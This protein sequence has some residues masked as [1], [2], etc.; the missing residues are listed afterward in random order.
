MQKKEDNI[1]ALNSI[2]KS[3]DN[4]TL[5]VTLDGK[6]IDQTTSN[7]LITDITNQLSAEQ[8][9][10]IIN[11][12]QVEYIN[13]NGL[14]SLISILTKTRTRGGE[15]ILCNINEKIEK[16]LLIT[17]LNSVFNTADSI[18][19]AIQKMNLFNQN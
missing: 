5:L 1:Q 15:V 10:V 4:R 11:L 13:S 18:E 12:E 2:F 19:D 6:I 9:R 16:L 8:N 7:Q 17:K 3:L 14:N